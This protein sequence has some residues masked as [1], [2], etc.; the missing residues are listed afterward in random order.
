VRKAWWWRWWLVGGIASV[1]GY[2]LLPVGGSWSAHTYE[3]IGLVS[4]LAILLAVRLHRPARPA[5]WYWFS[6]GQL[7]SVFG[8]FTYDFYAD[9][10]HRSPYPSVADIFYLGSYPVTFVGLILL[11]RR[12]TLADLVNAAIVATGL[13]LAFW[14][15]VLHPIAAESAASPIERL[16]SITYPTVDL[17]LLA[18]LAGQFTAPGGRTPS[19]RML[20]LAT[21]LVLAADVAF[22]VM[23]LYSGSDGHA[24]DAGFLL[25]YVF[26]AAAA[27]HPSMGVGDARSSRTFSRLPRLIALG[28]SSLLAPALLLLPRVSAN[29][30]DRTVVSI[31][32]I[33]LFLLVI[34]RMGGVMTE[35]QRMALH[36]ALTGLANRRRLE[37]AAPARL[38]VLGLSGFKNINDELGRP[39]GDHVLNALAG[40]LRSVAPGL[41]VARIGGDEFAVVPGPSDDDGA[42]A[43]R[44]GEAVRRPVAVAGHELLV[45]VG[46]GL[47]SCAAAGHCGSG[48]PLAAGG[49]CTA[50][51]SCVGGG[52]SEASRH[53]GAASRDET[54]L[55]VAEVLRRAEVAM[56]AAKQTGESHKRW[57]PELDERTAADARLGAELRAALDQ[58][59][60]RVVYQ[61]VVRLP[62]GVVHA[63][64]A[65][66][67]W[68]HP[69]RG[70]VSPAHF[71]PVAEQNG[72][73]VELGAWILRTACE[74]MVIWRATLGDRAPGKVSVN[75]SAR[76]LARP[77]FAGFV[78]A[79]LAAAGLPATF[80][81]VEVTET[82]VFEGGPA[83]AAL[84]E[85]RSLGVRIALDDFG[86]GHSSLG[87][88]Q[89][90]PVDTLK[91]DKSFVDRITEAGRHA[92]IAEALIQISEG[93]GLAAVAEGVE[94]AEQADALYR[95][96]YRLLQGYHFG[97]PV[98]DPDFDLVRATAASAVHVD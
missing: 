51:G 74:Q 82:A 59:Q 18:A 13:G 32:A 54:P 92:V 76:Q 60:F 39:V 87:L 47:S 35:V 72:L 10:L 43:E 89:T 61:P 27:L 9:V 78:A 71:I 45:G 25:S 65:L 46:I 81:V 37:Q 84:H 17:L 52:P 75:V 85:L 44:L 83:V 69:S 38:I 90:V 24:A 16:V 2:F 26:W 21:A 68:E 12:R 67:R 62:E 50:A 1:A 4:S 31:G 57:T 33:V 19:T 3:A 80:L 95:L 11:A 42:L 94:T 5:M 64:E 98:A 40:R 63:V 20:G 34:A 49:S 53:A 28:A 77:G 66:V 15:F 88:L 55:D 30:E 6:A 97:R 22:S 73:I 86:T 41:L 91:V 8:D 56:H 48:G 70:L 96:G 58:G 93:L 23:T 14:I 36:D 7:L 79:T 29:A